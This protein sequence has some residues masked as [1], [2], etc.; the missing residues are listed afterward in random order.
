MQHKRP[1]SILEIFPE[2]DVFYAISEPKS[3][4]Y[5][6]EVEKYSFN[7]LSYLKPAYKKTVCSRIFKNV[8]W[9]SNLTLLAYSLCNIIYQKLPGKEYKL[10]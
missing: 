8:L 2:K 1:N 5:R 7:T 3:S 10:L 4:G 6:A 9:N